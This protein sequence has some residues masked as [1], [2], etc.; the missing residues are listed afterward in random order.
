[1]KRSAVDQPVHQRRLASTTR[2]PE[3]TFGSSPEPVK[4]SSLPEGTSKIRTRGVAGVKTLTYQVTLTDGAQTSKKLLRQQITKQPATQV[5]AIGTNRPSS[6]TPT[7]AAPACRSPAT[8]TAPAAA[9]TVR[10]T[11]KGPCAS[12]ARTSTIWTATA[13]A[14]AAIDETAPRQCNEHQ[15]LYTA[16]A[17]TSSSAAS[18]FR[19]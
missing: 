3:G 12:S 18:S 17:H 4:D 6:A 5:V 13:T 10:P 16:A 11:S 15:A 9:A 14:S 1:M 19:Q 8:S 2:S 7:T